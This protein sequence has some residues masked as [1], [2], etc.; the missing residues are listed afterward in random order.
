MFDICRRKPSTAKAGT[1]STPPLAVE[2]NGLQQRSGAGRLPLQRCKAPCKIWKRLS[3]TGEKLTGITQNLATFQS[4]WGQKQSDSSVYKVYLQFAWFFSDI[5]STF[6][7]CRPALEGLFLAAAVLHLRSGPQRNDG[8]S[9]W[10]APQ[11]LWLGDLSKH[12][13]QHSQPFIAQVAKIPS[14]HCRIASDQAMLAKSMALSWR[15]DLLTPSP[16]VFRKRGWSIDIEAKHHLSV[17]QIFGS[18]IPVSELV[19]YIKHHET[20]VLSYCEKTTCISFHFIS[21]R[22]ISTIAHTI[23]RCCLYHFTETPGC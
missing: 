6:L 3:K 19:A 1:V 2:G 23:K 14:C 12:R 22:M 9:M 18:N 7:L 21:F 13:L 5:F 16:K 4:E 15:T 8:G 11:E 20:C 17:P 10:L